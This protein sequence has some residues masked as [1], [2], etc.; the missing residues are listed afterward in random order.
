MCALIIVPM[1]FVG[2]LVF[3]PS[4]SR[5]ELWT[6]EHPRNQSHLHLCQ[7]SPPRSHHHDDECQHPVLC[8]QTKDVTDFTNEQKTGE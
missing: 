4:G 8:V 1:N 3:R 6:S 2:I 5:C 7:K